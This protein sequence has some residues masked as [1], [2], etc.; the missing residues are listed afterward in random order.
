MAAKKKV[1]IKS[2][3]PKSLVKKKTSTSKQPAKKTS[4]PSKK[5][6]IVQPKKGFFPI[7]GIGASAGGLEAFES[8]F[9]EM[10]ENPQ[11][12]FVLVAHL[13]PSHVS[14]L[15]ELIQKK[16]KLKVQQVG[17]NMKVALNQV[18]IIP[19]NREMA[20][21]NGRLQLLEL[22]QPRGRNLPIDTFFRSLA[23]DQ[24]SNAVCIIL[25][26]TGTD[27]T[28]G[29]R[30]I[31]GEAG[32]VMVQDVESAKYD[33]MPRS[34][35]A[36][37]LVDYVLS[38]EEMPKQLLSYVQHI[39]KK[40]AGEIILQDDNIQNAMQK[41]FVL[42]RART[43]QDFS[44]YKK[45]TI[46]R[47][48]ER[49]MHVHQIDNIFDYVRYLQ[50]S[51]REVTILFKE[52]LIGVTNF[53]R[54]PV[55][56][57]LI[58][59]KFLPE[60]LKNKPDD[61]HVR[62]WVPGCSTGEEAYSI[63][64]IIQECMEMLGSHF[65]VQVFGTDI[66]EDAVNL[67]RT[68]LYPESIS[69]DID[70][71]RLKRFFTKEDNQYQIKK[72]IREMVIFA[73]Q[74]IIK[75]PPF[76]KLDML[77]CRNLLIYFN[78]ELQKKLLPVFHY[79]LKPNGILFL[80]SSETIG[81]ATDLFSL[82]EKKWKIFKR[83]PAEASQRPL[84]TFPTQ[85]PDGESPWKNIPEAVGKLKEVNTLQL[86]KTILKHSNI[87]ACI[88]IDD[89]ADII[90]IHGK[91]G[92]YLEPAEGETSI[93]VLEMA[94]PG[95]KVGLTNAIR[96]L[97]T[98]RQETVIKNLQIKFNGG[99]TNVNLTV[100]P[101]PDF[102]TGL[103]GLMM[104]VFEE[105]EPAQAKTKEKIVHTK[106]NK[107]SE[108][109]RKLEDE[110]QYT[111]ENLQTTI[112][113]LETSNEELKS[114]NEELQSTNEELQSTNEELETSKEELQSL[115]EESATV[116]SELQGRIVELS[117]ANDDMKNL[118]DSTEIA[119]LFL[120]TDFCI[121]RFTP[122][123]NSI[124]SLSNL[125]IGRPINHF[126][127]T[128]VDVDLIDYAKKV[129]DD[130]VLRS[131]EVKTESGDVYDMKI[132]PYRTINNVID[133]VVITFDDITRRKQVE[134][135]LEERRVLLEA[136]LECS[137]NGVVACDEKGN[138]TFF[139]EASR[140]FH[141]LPAKPIPSK[142]WAKHYD[143]FEMDGKTCMKH[144]N[145][146]LVRALNGED[147]VNQECV[148]AP[149]GLPARKMSVTGQTLVDCHGNKLGAVVSMNDI[150]NKII[151][152]G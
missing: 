1:G 102:K 125:D 124:C 62:I 52:L 9:M 120:D 33:G 117:N 81:L 34:A 89:Q 108:E 93:N 38:A 5:G 100:K 25:S 87:P 70:A 137:A 69:A 149:K 110:L 48:I 88:I 32:M 21:L 16:T 75:D 130:L 55:A 78:A 66:D 113:E 20:I 4:A 53:F 45:N 151:E 37:G 86:L 11:M 65:Q 83:K 132:R 8:F 145:L 126:A 28:L 98:D 22:S 118:L 72:A 76:T 115:N 92:R 42:L 109:V 13:D 6:S 131:L 82:E 47:R 56:F 7:V 17:D 39:S 40:P 142:Q 60:L 114:T 15:P 64:I 104:V 143:I 23:Q 35:I 26:G 134:K 27:G 91:T 105:E 85:L 140:V 43:D 128:I 57:D 58:K 36:T 24:G 67:A 71:D 30:A 141:G 77:C 29:V 41:I 3:T 111:R 61:Y 96:R 136:I 152:N 73:P 14:I 119:T 68:G 59:N 63:A 97:A 2:G 79:S 138:L 74:N 12:A 84:L 49:R 122:N 90:Y 19:P 106:Q 94:R 129:L 51:E 150:T 46:C 10:P 18:Y 80:G 103:R 44:L 123:T 144:G 133:G 107:K 127:T 139:N 99:Y 101:M 121:R 135:E 112:E 116:N 50:E 146:P 147:V 95:H 54:D 148:V 31:K